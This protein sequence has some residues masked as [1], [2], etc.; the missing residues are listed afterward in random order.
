MTL[1]VS[2]AAPVEILSPTRRIAL[3][4]VQV[5]RGAGLVVP[6][7]ALVEFTRALLLLG[8]A[9]PAAIY[10]AGRATLLTRPEQL[11]LYDRC[12]AAFFTSRSPGPAQ[13]GAEERAGSASPP[14]TRR[15]PTR[16]APR[17]APGSLATQREILRQRDFAT[18][19][20]EEREEA[21]ALLAEL[22][23]TPR[24]RVTRRHRP[25][26]R[27]GARPDLRA[28]VRR[29]V[30]R[31]GELYV[32]RYTEA[33]VRPRRVV[34]LLDVSG[35]MESYSRALLRFAQVAV[36]ARPLVEVFTLGT[37]LTRVTRELGGGD[38]ERALRA[39]VAAIP[40]LAGG[41]RL[42]E[43]LA[44]FNAA[45]G[46]R[47]LARGAVVVICSD[48]IDRGDPELLGAQLERLRLVA[49]LLLWVNPLKASDGYAPLARGM[50]AALPHLDRFLEG[51]SVA[52]L[53]DLASLF[54]GDRGG[55]RRPEG[56]GN[57]AETPLRLLR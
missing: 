16:R 11:A 25:S 18:L 12:F 5:L 42:G 30:R 34:L 4:L 49:H 31:R 10:F 45:F 28:V 47:G 21:V 23:F 24:E 44:S 55:R 33:V 15:P 27:H 48:G 52:A 51:H 56:T 26:G 37:R 39:S 22:R 6:T 19:S 20:A 2:G 1:S 17:S 14:A 40:D 8:L 43:S 54:S 57:G 29:S 9:D 35:S 53:A 46:V 36:A 38:P 13:L 50:A 32:D 41:T 3:G 7:G